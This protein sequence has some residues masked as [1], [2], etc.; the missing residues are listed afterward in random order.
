M[1]TTRWRMLLALAALVSA[2]RDPRDPSKAP[3]AG[4]DAGPATTPE[5]QPDTGHPIGPVATD[6]MPGASSPTAG[7]SSP[8]GTGGVAG[9]AGMAAV[10]GGPA[11]PVIGLLDRRPS[12]Q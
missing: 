1:T 8:I 6:G 2:C 3:L 4:P 5:V 11:R 12:S 10:G 7:G 9:M